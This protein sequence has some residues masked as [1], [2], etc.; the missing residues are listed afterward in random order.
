MWIPRKS[1]D[2]THSV[3]PHLKRHGHTAMQRRLALQDVLAAQ[4]IHLG[5]RQ[6]AS[7]QPEVPEVKVQVVKLISVDECEEQSSEGRKG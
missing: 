6:V 1:R 7:A 3:V 4:D 5:G 2:N